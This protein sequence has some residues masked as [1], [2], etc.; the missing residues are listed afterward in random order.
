MVILAALFG[1]LVLLGLTILGIGELVAA[2]AHGEWPGFA[3]ILLAIPLAIVAR[4][5]IAIGEHT[6]RGWQYGGGRGQKWAVGLLV[7][8]V[9]AGGAVGIAQLTVP[10]QRPDAQLVAAVRPA[11]AGQAIAGAGALD[12]SGARVNHLIVLDTDGNEHPWTGY[13]PMAWR[14][15]D[16]ADTELVACISADEIKTEIQVC[17][18]VNGPPIHRYR[19]SRQVRL[20]E[21]ATGRVIHQATV[22]DDPRACGHTESRDLTE[23]SGDVTWDDVAEHCRSFIDPGTPGQ[24]TLTPDRTSISTATPRPTLTGQ[25]VVRR[26]T[27]SAA[28]DQDLVRASLQGDGLQYV[29]LRLRSLTTSPLTVLVAAGTLFDPQRDA[30][31]SMVV[32]ADTEIDIAPGDNDS[33]QVPVACAEMRRDQPSGDDTFSIR[34]GAA[35]GDLARLLDTDEFA[36]QDFRVQQFAV[37]TITNNPLRRSYTGLGSTFSVFGT[38]PSDEEFDAIRDLFEAAGINPRDYRAF[39]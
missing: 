33:W 8:I 3:L 11:C 12:R 35:S 14:P 15:P 38:G 37:W 36:D 20:V 31:Q 16:L 5:P 1:I 6:I 10:S 13:P 32:I 25:P 23:L 9:A 29:D 39:R 24:P 4:I 34:P 7:W 2:Q 26:L 30:T 28:I 22:S 19:I 27:L 18:Y 21:A 17:Q